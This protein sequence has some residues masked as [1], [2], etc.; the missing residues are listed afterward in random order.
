MSHAYRNNRLPYLTEEETWIGRG[1][2]AVLE[3][4]DSE[5]NVEADCARL[6]I[7]FSWLCAG[8]REDVIRDGATL[9]CPACLATWLVW[10]WAVP[11]V[12]NAPGIR[13]YLD[14]MIRESR[15]PNIIHSDGLCKQP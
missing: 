1:A 9:T 2:L 5:G 13:R 11:E 14:A 6:G 15:A 10:E 8:C 4:G 12:S 3:Y 7:L